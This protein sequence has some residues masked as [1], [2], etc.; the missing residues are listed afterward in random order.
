MIGPSH[1]PNIF[2][3]SCLLTG[4]FPATSL[5]VPPSWPDQ[6]MGPAVNADLPASVRLGGMTINFEA[7]HLSEVAAALGGM[8]EH[9]G[10]AAG[11]RYWLCYSIA[12]GGQVWVISGGE[13]GGDEHRVT[14]MVLDRQIVD[15]NCQDAGNLS[16]TLMDG[17]SIGDTVADLMKRLG[18]PSSQ[19][20]NETAYHTEARFGDDGRCT[21]NRYLDAIAENG[22]IVRI[23]A[24]QITSC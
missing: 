12:T 14:S 10:D 6:A 18:S 2:I 11:S 20:L 23:T 9:A 7:T 5:A 24:G 16:V 19:N 21:T 4:L 17:V 13:M 1:T 3:L 8:I 22:L 15:P